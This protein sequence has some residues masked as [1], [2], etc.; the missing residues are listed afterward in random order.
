[1][2]FDTFWSIYPRKV[3]KHS[4]FRAYQKA[5]KVTDHAT[6]IAGATQYQVKC[7]NTEQCYIAHASTWLNGRRWEDDRGA[8]D[9]GI[10]PKGNG[11]NNRQSQTGAAISAA[12]KV[13]QKKRAGG[14]DHHGNLPD[15]PKGKGGQ[16]DGNDYWL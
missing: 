16:E 13:M 1:M 15:Q 12:I 9:S 2:S 10:N 7:S 6:L 8:D 14:A 11:H 3:G 5:L 4:A